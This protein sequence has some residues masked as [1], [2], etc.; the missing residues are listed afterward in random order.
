MS[1]GCT[2]FLLAS[3][4]V[5]D[6]LLLSSRSLPGAGSPGRRCRHIWGP[7]S[8]RHLHFRLTRHLHLA[9]PLRPATACLILARRATAP[10]PP[11]DTSFDMGLPGFPLERKQTRAFIVR[12]DDF[13]R[14]I[15]SSYD[16]VNNGVETDG[17]PMAGSAR[18]VR[19]VASRRHF[20]T[21]LW[22]GP[23]LDPVFA[24]HELRA[25]RG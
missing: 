2:T 16:I 15:R 11:R 18:E 17:V 21:P 13:N 3:G 1:V 25:R 9:W 6:R 8:A 19:N 5:P 22:S 24:T 4:T 23:V 12:T 14:V 20:P 7:A 10:R